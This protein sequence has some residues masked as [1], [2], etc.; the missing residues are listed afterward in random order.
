ME[1][2][3]DSIIALSLSIPSRFKFDNEEVI[4]HVRASVFVH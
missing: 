3:M 1:T 2:Q 4:D